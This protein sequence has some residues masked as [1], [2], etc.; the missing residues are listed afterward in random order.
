[1]FITFEGMDG[2]GKSTQI[3]ALR[4]FFDEKGIECY[5]TREPGGTD[6]GDKLRDIVLDP[7]NCDMDPVTEALVYAA[8]RAQLVSRVI[9][10]LLERGVNVVCDRFLD[11]SIAYQAYGRGLGS[12]DEAI[13]GPATGGLS[14]DIT[15]F[16]DVPPE[17]GI[18]R[19][20]EVRNK[21]EGASL[22]RLELEGIGFKSRVYEGFKSIA[23][24]EPERFIV[25]DGRRSAD[26]IAQEIQSIVCGLI[27]E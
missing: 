17:I 14:P 12:A 11:S 1:M 16:L 7:A 13:N 24:K 4:E 3:A 8:S 15:F 25:I 26:E 22:D 21:A 20:T 5:F 18:A 2:S 19:I 9:V 6:I 23:E 27:G 10:P